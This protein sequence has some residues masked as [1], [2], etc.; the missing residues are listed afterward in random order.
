MKRAITYGTFDMFHIGHLKLIE[1]IKLE[2]DHLTVA[3]STDEFNTV[4]GKKTVIP[5]ADRAAIVGSLRLVDQVI[6]ENNWEQKVT[7]IEKNKIDLFVIGSDWSG[8]FDF[9]KSQCQVLYL[10]RTP[11]VSSTQLKNSLGVQMTELKSSLFSRIDDLQK[12]IDDLPD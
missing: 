3:V 2:C 9:L 5:F 8:K 12:L 1:R 7:D 6:P 11:G 4:K 10:E